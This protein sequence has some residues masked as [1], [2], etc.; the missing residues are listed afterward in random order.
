MEGFVARQNIKHYRE[1]LKITTDPARRRL[2]EELISKQEAKLKKSE[3][4]HSARPR[5][6]ANLGSKNRASRV[7]NID[8]QLTRPFWIISY[9]SVVKWGCPL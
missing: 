9:R 1:M 3:E 6:S 7:R 2:I 5:A 8:R 4:D